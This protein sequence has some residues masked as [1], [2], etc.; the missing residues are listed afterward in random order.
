MIR[1]VLVDIDGVLRD[2]MGY[3]YYLYQKKYP[4]HNFSKVKTW[5]MAEYFPIGEDIYTFV[6]D[7][8]AEEITANAKP[9][10]GAIEALKENME[11]F[12][13]ALVSAQNE[14]GMIGTLQWLAKH[15]VPIREYHFCFD[16]EKVEGD[17][18]LDDGPHNLE[19]FSETGRL[20]IARKQ[21]WNDGWKGPKV[22]SVSDF[23]QY[24][25]KINEAESLSNNV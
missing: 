10:P 23:F 11:K 4:E 2:Y 6:F 19:A 3:V 5:S 21:P 14:K 24:I 8:H 15:R 17:A 18:L 13:I 7:L 16:K 25:L 1:K 20:A 9:I 22:D 12:D